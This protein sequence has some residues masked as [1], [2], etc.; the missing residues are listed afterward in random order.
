[1][2]RAA[3]L[4]NVRLTLLDLVDGSTARSSG[5]REQCAGHQPQVG[6]VQCPSHPATPATIP[7][8]IARSDQEIDQRAHAVGAALLAASTTSDD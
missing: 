3:R 2:D 8:A 7:F 4:W 1:M 5:A 6:L